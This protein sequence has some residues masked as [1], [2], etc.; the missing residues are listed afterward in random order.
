M[1]DG[2]AIMNRRRDDEIV[3]P[4]WRPAPGVRCTFGNMEGPAND[5]ARQAHIT[6]GLALKVIDGGTESD[7]GNAFLAT[8][9]LVNMCQD[10]RAL[11]YVA[12]AGE[13]GGES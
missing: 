2:G 12:H 8:E 5:L 7:Q 13:K 3:T 11:F 4:W 1:G 10:I 9:I 6:I